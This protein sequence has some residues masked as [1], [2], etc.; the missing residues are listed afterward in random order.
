MA[1]VN[2]LP[3]NYQRNNRSYDRPIPSGVTTSFFLNTTDPVTSP[4]IGNIRLSVFDA[5]GTE[6]ISDI[7]T[8]Q[9]TSDD[10]LYVEDMIITG[11]V[12]GTRYSLIMY[13]TSNDEVL[14]DL[15]C[16]RYVEIDDIYVEVSYRNSS[17]IFNFGYEELPTFRNVI[18]LDLNVIDNQAELERTQYTEGS[19]G[20]VRNQKSQYKEFSILESYFFDEIAHGG[21]KGLSAHDDILLNG[22]PYQVKEPYEIETNIRSRKSK[23]TI[24]MYNQTINEINLNF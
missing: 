10:R 22:E 13:D 24:E 21:M 3:N 9:I 18:Y 14:F 7:E 15:G 2:T 5:Y 4:I 6:V 19:T 11:L 1:I 12:Y 16:F 8:V 20:Y 23:G 17:D